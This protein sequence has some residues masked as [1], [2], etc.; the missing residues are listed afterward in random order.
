VPRH[1]AAAPL[2][3]LRMPEAQPLR[4]RGYRQ[5]AGRFS[6]AGQNL[7]CHGEQ[8]LWQG[9]GR[10]GVQARVVGLSGDHRPPD[11]HR[12]ERRRRWS[13]DRESVSPDALQRLHG[14]RH[15]GFPRPGCGRRPVFGQVNPKPLSDMHE[16]GG[17]IRRQ[18]RM[19]D[20]RLR[21]PTGRPLRR[22]GRL[23]PK[24][25][26]RSRTSALMPRMGRQHIKG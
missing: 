10:D 17:A 7:H 21:G 5:R 25:D 9:A 11:P 6:R 13:R 16:D 1:S 12:G 3:S 18:T 14:G 4:R 8:L 19:G 22:C 23:G 24:S 20:A 15:G 26:N 2:H